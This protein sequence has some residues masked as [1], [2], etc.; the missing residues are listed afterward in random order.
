MAR[1]SPRLG[2][3]QLLLANPPPGSQGATQGPEVTKKP[4]HPISSQIARVLQRPR[5]STSAAAGLQLPSTIFYSSDFSYDTCAT[6]HLS[7][8]QPLNQ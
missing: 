6:V 2:L 8:K 7:E 5:C 1:E 4:H 3:A